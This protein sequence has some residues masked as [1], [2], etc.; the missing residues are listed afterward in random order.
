[1]ESNRKNIIVCIDDKNSNLYLYV[2]HFPARLGWGIDISHSDKSFTRFL[3]TCFFLA[4]LGLYSAYSWYNPMIISFM[5]KFQPRKSCVTFSVSH[6]WMFCFASEPRTCKIDLFLKICGCE[7]CIFRQYL[8]VRYLSPE[9][10]VTDGYKSR[11]GSEASVRMDVCCWWN[12]LHG[13]EYGYGKTKDILTT[14]LIIAL[15][16]AANCINVIMEAA[17]R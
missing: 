7:I 3:L 4:H 9:Q 6:S 11:N 5:L 1:M 10:M 14:S 13:W 17:T 15:I 16:T 12:W 8:S 2:K